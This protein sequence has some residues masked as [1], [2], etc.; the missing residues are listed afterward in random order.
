[1][2]KCK[3][4]TNIY[5]KD[6]LNFFRRYFFENKGYQATQPVIDTF[7]Q[8]IRDRLIVSARRDLEY[9]HGFFQWN[10]KGT[11]I[12]WKVDPLEHDVVCYIPLDQQ[13]WEFWYDD[14]DCIFASFGQAILYEGKMFRK[15]PAPTGCHSFI[16]LEYNYV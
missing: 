11:S 6:I 16:Q 2:S 10:E 1:L 14:K 15:R 7:E 8:E 12:P 9:K 4:L 13:R 5:S 3:V